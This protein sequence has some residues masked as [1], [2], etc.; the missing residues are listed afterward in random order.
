MCRN[1]LPDFRWFGKPWKTNYPKWLKMFIWHI[2]RL[3]HKHA[4]S[5]LIINKRHGGKQNM[6]NI[7]TFPSFFLPILPL[8]RDSLHLVGIPHEIGT[9]Q[10]ISNQKNSRQSRTKNESDAFLRLVYVWATNETI[11]LSIYLSMYTL[12]CV[13]VCVAVHVWVLYLCAAHFENDGIINKVAV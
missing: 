9:R 6:K 12:E 8:R 1:F 5:W 11:S 3:S 2:F 4:S 10:N 13:A 7:A